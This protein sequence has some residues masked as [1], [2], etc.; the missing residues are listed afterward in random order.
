MTHADHIL[1]AED[2]PNIRLGLVDTLESEGYRV[3]QA[4][5]GREA[6]DL[7]LRGGHDL[8]LLDIMMPEKSG[9]D[10]CREIRSTDPDIPVIMLT[11]KAEE[12]DTVVGLQLG[13]DD[14]ITKPFGVHELLARISAVLRRSGRASRS[15]AGE[16]RETDQEFRFGGHLVDARGYTLTR[17]DRVFKLSQRE[18]NLIRL[19]HA[20]P[21]E[22][23]A[24]DRI[25]NDIWGVSYY[26]TTRTLDQHVAQL[27][28]KVEQDP[29]NPSLITT[30][31]GIGYRYSGQ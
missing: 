28:K 4:V 22:V 10:V 12:I 15:A 2:D 14:Y 18:L 21:G 19:F 1:V 9:Y 20:H 7:F 16:S 25:L 27:R 6:M 23:L 8:V 11:A 17:E 13:A 5:N 31:H 3:T 26:G 29:A 24:R 30:V